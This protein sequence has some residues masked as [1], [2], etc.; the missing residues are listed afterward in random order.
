MFL[1]S[2]D[3][4]ETLT[5][6]ALRAGIRLDAL[7][8]AAT[9]VA[10]YADEGL[11]IVEE[12]YRPK[13]HCREGCAYCCCKPGVL[14]T[15][16][17]F[18]RL[19]DY[20]RRTF[21]PDALDAL[22]DRANGYAS[23]MEGRRFDDPLDEI[24]PCPLLVNSRCSIYEVRPLVCRGYNSTDVDSCQAASQDAGVTI[25]ICSV[26][27]DVTDASTVGMAHGLRTAGLSD[28][29]IDL[30]TALHIAL[31]AGDAFPATIGDGSGALAPAENAM[32]VGELWNRVCE[33]ARQIGIPIPP[34]DSAGPL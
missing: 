1:A 8:A 22:R 11:A 24:V 27:K 25:P 31:T 33:T 17:E 20:V 15:I 4:A 16:P 19:L 18:L 32:W 5:R 7:I 28:V 13:L 26:L 12:A 30:G 10:E 2:R 29:L 23:Q 6:D 14:V 21:A 9:H 34:A 3:T